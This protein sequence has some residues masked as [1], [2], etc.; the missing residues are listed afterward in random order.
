VDNFHEVLPLVEK[1]WLSWKKYSKLLAEKGQ[2]KVFKFILQPFADD[3]NLENP[4]IFANLPEEMKQKHASDLEQIRETNPELWEFIQQHAK[5]VTTLP[6]EL[7]QAVSVN[8]C[9]M[10]SDYALMGADGIF[11][12]C[13]V[14]AAVMRQFNL[15]SISENNDQL[16]SR[17]QQ[18]LTQIPGR[19]KLACRITKTYMGSMVK[20][21]FDIN[22]AIENHYRRA[23]NGNPQVPESIV[24]TVKYLDVNRF[25][26][27]G[28]YEIPSEVFYQDFW[29]DALTVSEQNELKDV[30]AEAVNKVINGV[31][32][33]VVLSTDEMEALFLDLTKIVLGEKRFLEIMLWAEKRNSQLDK[34]AQNIYD[35][36]GF[37][38]WK[39]KIKASA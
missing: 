4:F 34:E 35:S 26:K 29:G 9:W 31:V 20:R 28:Y 11:Y 2:T 12:P 13:C 16:C 18:A 33:S 32:L 5:Q 36:L 37:K 21:S 23:V 15:G 14:M 30:F 8:E 10:V 1:L 38:G 17:R 27:W 19:C 25:S 6:F 22:A 24:D 3:T 39:D 7:H